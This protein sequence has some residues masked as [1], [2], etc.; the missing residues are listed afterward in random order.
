M[1]D[2][3]LEYIGRAKREAEKFRRGSGAEMA[4]KEDRET[5]KIKGFLAEELA[6]LG[7]RRGA[8]RLVTTPKEIAERTGLDVETVERWLSEAAKRRAGGKVAVIRVGGTDVVVRLTS[9]G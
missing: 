3:V 7:V 5:A 1:R 8:K 4:R 9:R 2:E 6:E